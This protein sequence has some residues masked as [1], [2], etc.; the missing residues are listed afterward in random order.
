MQRLRQQNHCWPVHAPAYHQE[1]G[2]SATETEGHD[3]F[4]TKPMHQLRHQEKNPYFADHAYRPQPAD[5]ALAVA[6]LNQVNRIKCV[7]GAMRKRHQHA[8]REKG[9]HFRAPEYLPYRSSIR[10]MSHNFPFGNLA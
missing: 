7:I 8:G 10:V 1:P 5:D 4:E 3:L 9:N 6:V 2:D